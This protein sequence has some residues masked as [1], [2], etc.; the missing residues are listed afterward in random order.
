[1]VPDTFERS[2]RDSVESALREM[3]E[4]YPRVRGGCP[5]A[6]VVLDKLLGYLYPEEPLGEPLEAW[7]KLASKVFTSQRFVE[8]FLP[9]SNI[10][11]AGQLTVCRRLQSLLEKLALATDGNTGS[12]TY[13]VLKQRTDDG[14][15][16][17]DPL[18]GGW[19][20]L[21]VMKTASGRRRLT[22]L[23][24]DTTSNSSSKRIRTVA[25]LLSM[26]EV[27]EDLCKKYPDDAVPPR[28]EVY[29]DEDEDDGD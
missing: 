17:Y 21:K 7:Q 8:N 29:E 15:V 16:S 23:F 10:P 26:M 12:V 4:W 24:L 13:L 20:A 19:G 9:Q 22:E 28:V 6:P 1:M 27:I 14:T 18:G 3:N 2:V 11:V 25:E 5:E